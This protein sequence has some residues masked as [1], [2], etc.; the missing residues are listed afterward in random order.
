MLDVDDLDAPRADSARV[1]DKW[2]DVKAAHSTG[3]TVSHSRGMP[4]HTRLEKDNSFGEFVFLTLCRAW[5]EA[6]PGGRTRVVVPALPRASFLRPMP[7]ARRG[8]DSATALC[9]RM[10]AALPESATPLFSWICDRLA[11]HHS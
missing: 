5:D 11:V 6:S 1:A 2:R 7:A 10:G 3:I 9:T 4:A 8:L